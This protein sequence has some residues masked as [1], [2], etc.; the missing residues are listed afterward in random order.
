MVSAKRGASFA[1]SSPLMSCLQKDKVRYL[2]QTNFESLVSVVWHAHCIP[3]LSS[4]DPT[5]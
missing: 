2:S 3:L 4:C 1:D 5:F